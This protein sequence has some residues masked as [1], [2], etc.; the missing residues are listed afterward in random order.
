MQ[1]QSWMS[2]FGDTLYNVKMVEENVSLIG[3]EVK[4]NIAEKLFSLGHETHNTCTRK[5]LI[6]ECE[7]Y[8]KDVIYETPA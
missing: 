5:T 7:T 4:N 8:K 2:F 3:Q 1:Y 6:V